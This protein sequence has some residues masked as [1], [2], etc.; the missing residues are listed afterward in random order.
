MRL[1]LPVSL[2]MVERGLSSANRSELRAARYSA[3]FSSAGRSLETAVIIPNTVEISASRPRPARI[4]ARRSRLSLGLCGP[5]GPAGR[6]R[7][8]LRGVTE[9]DI[10]VAESPAREAVRRGRRPVPRVPSR[11]PRQGEAL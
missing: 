7:A 11:R 8:D 5:G 6:G 2:A 3:A 1:L 10:D 4:S 9:A